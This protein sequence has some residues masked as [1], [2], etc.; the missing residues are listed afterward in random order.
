MW[1]YKCHYASLPGSECQYV[2]L[3][4]V[5]SIYQLCES[6]TR[7]CKYLSLP[8]RVPFWWSFCECTSA[9][10]QVD[11]DLSANMWVYWEC[12]VSTKLCESATR[13][14]KY[15]SL[16]IVWNLLWVYQRLYQCHYVGLLCRI[17][18]PMCES[19]RSVQVKTIVELLSIVPVPPFQCVRSVKT[20]MVPLCV[21]QPIIV[22]V[23]LWKSWVLPSSQCHC[24]S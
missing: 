18:V 16:K 17:R 12:V 14:C 22:P 9:I 11:Q 10:M 5:C 6:A 7:L 15:L 4:G 3:L 23:P 2:S 1:V 21:S 13:L 24:G 20:T 8:F 19:T